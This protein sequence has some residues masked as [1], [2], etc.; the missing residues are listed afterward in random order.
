M[1]C[2]ALTQARRK[3]RLL[4][5]AATVGRCLVPS[6][7]CHSHVTVLALLCTQVCSRRLDSDNTSAVQEHMAPGSVYVVVNGQRTCAQPAA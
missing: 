1:F 3:H 2:S 7:L 4:H 6:M 5:Q